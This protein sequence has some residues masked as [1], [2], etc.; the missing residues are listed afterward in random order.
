MK[1]SVSLILV[2][3]LLLGCFTSCGISTLFSDAISGDSEATP[4]VEEMI[5]ALAEKNI[6]EAKKLMHP[7]VADESDDDI[8]RMSEYLDGRDAESVKATNIS[9]NTSTGTSGK[10]R[11]ERITYE[12]TLEDGEVISLNVVYLSNK[13]GEGFY[14]FSIAI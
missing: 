11:E 14:S 6:P 3:L 1:K 4:K 7:E 12:V 8:E 5:T 9:I 2:I 10:V 13:V